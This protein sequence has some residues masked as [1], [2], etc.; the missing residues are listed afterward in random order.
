MKQMNRTQNKNGGIQ[1]ALGLVLALATNLA[2]AD[3]GHVIFKVG[4]AKRISADGSEQVLMKGDA[5][6]AGDTIVTNG[7]GMV[8]LRMDDGGLFAIRP[9]SQFRIDEYVYEENAASDK[10]FFSLI[11]G[12]FRSVTGAI[13]QKNK[14]A[15]KVKTPVATIGIRGTDYS[16]R[17]CSADCGA[18]ANN[19][20]YVGVMSGGVTVASGS[21]SIDLDPSQY[22]FVD[23]AS[24]QAVPLDNAPGDLLFAKAGSGDTGTNVASAGSDNSG[25]T[26]DNVAESDSTDTQ[27]MAPATEQLAVTEAVINEELL[28]EESLVTSKRTIIMADAANNI[29]TTA[30]TSDTGTGAAVDWGYW[31][32]GSSPTVTLADGSTYNASENSAWVEG[33]FQVNLPVTGTASYAMVSGSGYALSGDTATVD[34]TGATLDADFSAMLATATVDVSV[35][36][37]GTAETWA[38]VATDLAIA[39]DTG[40]FTVD[41]GTTMST[42]VDVGFG[43]TSVQGD[44]SGGFTN[45]GASETPDGAVFAYTMSSGATSGVSGSVILQ[46]Q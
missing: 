17:L 32:T 14:K 40:L 31:G 39:A 34:V 11:K 26:T 36:N 3:A 30:I 44:I 18:G 1:L 35:T 5:V 13:G 27:Q 28:V 24:G 41:T 9:N 37:G 38:A 25:N 6:E 12:G 15:Y 21:D 19:G 42:T 2:W 29:I 33:D 8:Q 7:H 22:G 46:A 20:L 4:E 43:P 23:A 16:A 45:S 10:N